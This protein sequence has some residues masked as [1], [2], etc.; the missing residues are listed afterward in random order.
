M[1]LEEQ[2]G[3]HTS[4]QSVP[5]E[6]PSMRHHEVKSVT[7]WHWYF[8]S[9]SC[10]GTKEGFA[11]T[12]YFL[13]LLCWH[14]TQIHYGFLWLVPFLETA[15]S[16]E[17]SGTKIVYLPSLMKA[18][19]ASS[20]ALLGQLPTLPRL[21]RGKLVDNGLLCWVLHL[22]RFSCTL[23]SVTTH[24]HSAPFQSGLTY[25]SEPE[26]IFLVVNFLVQLNGGLLSFK[27]Y[28]W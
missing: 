11:V 6:S 7:T 24:L 26:G 17:S 19:N 10:Y 27:K 20:Q 1:P 12:H 4:P 28:L 23:S 9:Q 18:V 13:K 14:K 15:I 5:T 2:C 22:H 25:M 16:S 3:A 21:L 8:Y